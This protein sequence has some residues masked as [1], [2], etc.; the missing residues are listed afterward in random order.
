MTL[1]REVGVSVQPRP[2]EEGSWATTQKGGGCGQKRAWPPLSSQMQNVGR[3]FLEGLA[4][5]C[6]D[7]GEKGSQSPGH[8][9]KWEAEQGSPGQ[10]HEVKELQSLE[11]KGCTSHR[12]SQCHGKKWISPTLGDSLPRQGVPAG[13]AC[14]VSRRVTKGQGH[15]QW[16]APSW[17]ASE[18]PTHVPTRE[19]AHP[20]LSL[21]T[22]YSQPRDQS[23]NHSSRVHQAK[24]LWPF[25]VISPLPAHSLLLPWRAEDQE[26]NESRVTGHSWAGRE[27]SFGWERSRSG[28]V[29][30]KDLLLPKC[31]SGLS[32]WPF[33]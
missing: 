4:M 23:E 9:W 19:S 20:C 1:K 10:R 26:Q 28:D 30:R 27:R 6:Q 11:G 5:G 24:R 31:E 8:L 12:P 33:S 16:G 17:G 13:R 29:I 7:F 22:L 14:V 32:R 21:E 3:L 2:G 25:S 15:G 18:S